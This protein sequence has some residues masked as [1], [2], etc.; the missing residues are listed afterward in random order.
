MHD[1]NLTLPDWYA[2]VIKKN[3]QEII[4]LTR[5][6]VADAFFSKKG[7]VHNMM[8][9]GLQL[10]CKLRDDADLLY[11]SDKSKPGKRGRP[12]TYAGKVDPLNI[13]PEYFHEV[14][15]DKGI[16]AESAKVYSK[17]L[18]RNILLVVEKFNLKGKMIYRLLFSTD[19]EQSPMDVIDIYHTCF[20]IEFGFRDARHILK[21]RLIFIL[22][23]L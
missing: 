8:A 15:N 18:Q 12:S 19:L 9:M 23:Q 10:V 22:I 14:E 4:P 20:Q 5:Y 16:K 7:F 1:H 3:L 2:A 13:N 6:L 21:T 17:S 11:L